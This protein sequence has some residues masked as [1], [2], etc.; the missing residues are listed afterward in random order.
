MT[1]FIFIILY[2]LLGIGIS[3]IPAF[4]FVKLAKIKTPALLLAT[5]IYILIAIITFL[6]A[7]SS[8]DNEAFLW[9]ILWPIALVGSIATFFGFNFF[10]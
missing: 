1:S 6:I 2:I 3:Y 9:G 10:N 8:G 4:F 5:I 7:T